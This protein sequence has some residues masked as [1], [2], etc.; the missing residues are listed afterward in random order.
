MQ[1]E[2]ETKLLI[3]LDTGGLTVEEDF[4]LVLDDEGA[5]S[6]PEGRDDGCSVDDFY[7]WNPESSFRRGD[8]LEGGHWMEQMKELEK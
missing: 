5:C 3:C 4:S 8:D 7:F 6:W 1:E 2:L